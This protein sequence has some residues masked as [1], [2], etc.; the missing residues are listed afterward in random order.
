[1]SGKQYSLRPKQEEAILK[2]S[3]ETLTPFTGR[4]PVGWRAPSWQLSAKS[5]D[6]VAKHGFEYSSNMMDR[7]VP[8]L[9]PETHGVTNFAVESHH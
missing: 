8:Y 4:R 9:H 6:L 2:K 1:M 3:I 7:L 5:L